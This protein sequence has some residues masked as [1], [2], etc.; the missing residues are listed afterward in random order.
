[1]TVTLTRFT[2]YIN[3]F[4]PKVQSPNPQ[5]M[6]APQFMYALLFFFHPKTTLRFTIPK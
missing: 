2:L 4:Y 6:K 3:F 1:M 5:F